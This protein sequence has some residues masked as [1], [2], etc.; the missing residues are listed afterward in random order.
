MPDLQK[1]KKNVEERAGLKGNEAMKPWVR[2]IYKVGKSWGQASGNEYRIQER[3]L[4]R[5]GFVWGGG[6]LGGGEGRKRSES[7]TR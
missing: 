6:G 5:G 7:L 4:W 2:G 1:K 3:K